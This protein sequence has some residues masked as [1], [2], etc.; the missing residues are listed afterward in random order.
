V[1]NLLSERKGRPTLVRKT[2]NTTVVLDHVLPDFAK[3]T[4]SGL[5]TELE[6]AISGN[7]VGEFQIHHDNPEQ[8]L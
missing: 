7:I 8:T 1:A 3:I 6:K 4:Y 5:T 2:E